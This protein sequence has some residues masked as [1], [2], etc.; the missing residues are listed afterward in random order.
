M[1]S[2][3]VAFR[4]KTPYLHSMYAPMAWLVDSADCY[5]PCNVT[6]EEEEKLIE[7]C[8]EPLTGVYEWQLYQGSILRKNISLSEAKSKAALDKKNTFMGNVTTTEDEAQ[9]K[10]KVRLSAKARDLLH[11]AYWDNKEEENE[12]NFRLSP[13]PPFPTYKRKNTVEN[14]ADNRKSMKI[15]HTAKKKYSKILSSPEINVTY[16]PETS[17]DKQLTLQITSENRNKSL[18]IFSHQIESNVTSGSSMFEDMYPSV[19]NRVQSSTDRASSTSRL[20]VLGNWSPAKSR[21]QSPT[22]MAAGLTSSPI[23]TSSP[24]IRVTA[25][26]DS[27]VWCNG[28]LENLYKHR[29]KASDMSQT[30][31]NQ[32]MLNFTYVVMDAL[33]INTVLRNR[34]RSASSKSQTNRDSSDDDAVEDD[35]VLGRLPMTTKEQYYKLEEKLK[36]ESFVK[37]WKKLLLERLKALKLDT[38][39]TTT[40]AK[41]IM[42]EIFSQD[43]LKNMCYAG[44]KTYKEKKM[45][46]KNGIVYITLIAVLKKLGHK[47]VMKIEKG[48]KDAMYKANDNITK[49]IRKKKLE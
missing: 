19:M 4:F 8:V 24:N 30:E 36:N 2:N 44:H 23:R 22:A 18:E 46:V 21:E 9:P 41:M 15:T 38:L 16:T 35:S 49:E 26:A 37:T 43:M 13:A 5:W 48:L 17:A 39:A 1:S 42:S 14:N 47:D 20:S 32:H 29:K 25:D 11:P 12:N 27:D 31:F 34:K 40:A 45:A 28:T 7:S 10:R 33:N 6:E 3:Y